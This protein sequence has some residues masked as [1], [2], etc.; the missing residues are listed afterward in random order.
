MYGHVIYNKGGTAEKW[1]NWFWD[2]HVSIWD[3]CHLRVKND[4]LKYQEQ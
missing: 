3:I 4:F 2:N 1:E